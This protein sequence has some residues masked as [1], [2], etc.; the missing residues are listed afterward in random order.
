MLRAHE[1]HCIKLFA[2]R[3]VEDEQFRKYSKFWNRADE[4]HRV[5]AREAC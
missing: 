4:L 3:A 2:G 5:P 1:F